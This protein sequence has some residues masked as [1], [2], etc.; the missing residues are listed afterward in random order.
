MSSSPAEISYPPVPVV[1]QV[2]QQQQQPGKTTMSM[3]NVQEGSKQDGAAM[4]LRG[5]CPGHL[6]G[7]PILPCHCDICIIPCCF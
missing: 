7:L 2:Q 5:G 3:N 4:R 6:C 1:Q